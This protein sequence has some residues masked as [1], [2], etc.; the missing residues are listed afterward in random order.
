[1]REFKRSTTRMCEMLEA[2]LFKLGYW[3]FWIIWNALGL[4]W[5][6]RAAIA[7]IEKADERD[8][9]RTLRRLKA[10]KRCGEAV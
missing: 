8:S 1:M 10:L 5:L 2:V 6:F 7:V 9:E 3:V 4:K